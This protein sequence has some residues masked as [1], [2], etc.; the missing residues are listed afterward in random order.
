V[1]PNL[2]ALVCAVGTI[3]LTA[4]LD[5]ADGLSIELDPATHT[6]HVSGGVTAELSVPAA[7]TA[8]DIKASFADG[9]LTV[10]VTKPVHAA[11]RVKIAL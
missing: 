1:Y 10:T 2:P 8:S 11:K 5:S 7:V 9:L 6:V 3:T 4:P